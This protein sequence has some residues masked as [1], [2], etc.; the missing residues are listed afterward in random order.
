MSGNTPSRPWSIGTGRWSGGS[1]ARSSATSTTPRTPSRPRSWS[2]CG[3][4]ARSGCA[5][6]WG[7]GSIGSPAGPRSAPGSRRVDGGRRSGGRSRWRGERRMS[8]VGDDLG[9]LIH[10]EID[11]L[12]DRYR[13]PVVLCDVEGRSYEEAARH[14]R[15]PVGTVKSRLAHGRERLRERLT[16]QG[17]AGA[18]R[19]AGR[20]RHPEGSPAPVALIPATVR[21]ALAFATRGAVEGGVFSASVVSLARGVSMSLFFQK[22][23][24]VVMIALV[25]VVVAF[26][27]GLFLRAATGPRGIRRR[28]RP[29]RAAAEQKPADSSKALVG[30]VRDETGQPVAGA[31]VVAGQFNG[32]PNHRIGHDWT[33][34]PLLADSG[35][36]I[37][38]PGICPGLQGRARPGQWL[39]HQG[40]QTKRAT[41]CSCSPGP[42]R[43]RAS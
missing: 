24:G 21:A 32:K 37:G 12:P 1:V 9:G 20:G 27:G 35:R 31:T 17:L 38:D 7:P 34:W 14:L 15:C 29:R 39:A 10:E 28:P 4:P 40:R 5:T 8:S 41:S 2:W 30:I 42:L 23:R 36:S 22:I 11:R 6:R 19:L 3:G 25:A 26:G 43:S 16:R 13:M 18:R 33:G